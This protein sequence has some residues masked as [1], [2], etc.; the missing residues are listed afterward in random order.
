MARTHERSRHDG[1]LLEERR[2]TE[3]EVHRVPRRLPRA[4][5]FNASARIGTTPSTRP[6]A[7]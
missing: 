1:A 2:S 3:E 5:P 7:E 6:R 4:F